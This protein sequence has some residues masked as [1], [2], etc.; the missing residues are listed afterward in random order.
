M[1][2]TKPCT[3][4]AGLLSG[5]TMRRPIFKLFQ[6]QKREKMIDELF[7][8]GFKWPG[9]KKLLAWVLITIVF[10]LSDF[11]GKLAKN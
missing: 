9:K 6:N 10:E 7:I 3:L 8:V 5:A 2:K 1:S 11:M 4:G